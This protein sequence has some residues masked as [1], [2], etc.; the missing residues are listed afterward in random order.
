MKLTKKTG[1]VTGVLAGITMLIA[2]AAFAANTL[3]VDGSTASGTVNVTGSLSGTLSFATDSLP[4]V[5]ASCSN[6]AVSGTVARGGSVTAGSTIGQITNLTFGTAGTP[7]V[8]TSLN[9]PVLITKTPAGTKTPAAP[10]SWPIV[11]TATPAKGAA[12]VPIRI[13]SV[14]V[15]MQSTAKTGSPASYICDLRARGS[16][17][18]TFNQTTQQIVINPPSG[19]FPI[20]NITAYNGAG[21][22]TASP[23]GITCSNQ[24]YTGDSARM[25]G[26][27]T[28][29][30]PGVGGIHW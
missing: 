23:S 19:T 11:V 8:A 29:S 13:D 1:L 4:S 14:D 2:P 17:T 28:L 12:T 24:I 30:T 10:A 3:S 9:Y 18:G 16:V 5:P 15:K 26:T 27:F 22:N 6:A 21:T 7:C 25:T 20:N